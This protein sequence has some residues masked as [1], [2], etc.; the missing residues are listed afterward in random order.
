MID[1]TKSLDLQLLSFLAGDVGVSLT[2]SLGRD[3]PVETTELP[4]NG[5]KVAFTP[6]HV[7][8]VQARV[9]FGDKELP[10]GPLKFNVVP[11][12][13]DASK[14]Q[15][16]G[17][18][19]KPTGVRAS[20][21]VSFAVDATKAGGE[22][23][24]DVIIQVQCSIVLLILSDR[25]VSVQDFKLRGGGFKSHDRNWVRDSRF[26]YASPLI[27]LCCW[28]D[29]STREKSGHPPHNPRLRK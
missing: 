16:T 9:Y 4:N 24:L 29:G 23:D 11:G 5:F 22:A 17:D 7:G 10:G 8:P 15:V 1:A 20:L 27:V 26:T 28:K 13:V 12:D 2:D 18:G 19:V 3:I 6:E 25:I 14:V 21:P